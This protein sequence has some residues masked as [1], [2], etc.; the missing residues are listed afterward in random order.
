[1]VREDLTT[2]NPLFNILEHY[3]G[4]HWHQVPTRAGNEFPVIGEG[5]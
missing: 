2:G 4:V 1:M 3:C 5:K